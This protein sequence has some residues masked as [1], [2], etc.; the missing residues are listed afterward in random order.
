[1]DP[2]KSHG[3]WTLDEDL[4]LVEYVM[5][6][7]KRW[8]MIGKHLEDKRTEH[9]VKNRYNSLLSKYKKE[10]PNRKQL[11]ETN[12]M[13]EVQKELSSKKEREGEEEEEE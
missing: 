5:K 9:M 6:F 3:E 10:N 12:I 1:M 7:G 11:N 2:G 4:K 13:M 8:A